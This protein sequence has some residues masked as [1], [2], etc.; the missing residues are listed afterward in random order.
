MVQPRAQ[1]MQAREQKL[2]KMIDINPKRNTDCGAEIK[3]PE[4]QKMRK[5]VREFVCVNRENEKA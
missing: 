3:K 1:C 5:C 2:V 4:I